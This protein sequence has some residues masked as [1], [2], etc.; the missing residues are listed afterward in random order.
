MPGYKSKTIKAI[1]TKK[2]T[3]WIE[4]VK[5]ENLRTLLKRDVI[6]TGGS[7]ASMLQGE[8]VNDFDIYFRT[9]ETTAKVAQYYTEE[10]VTR[11]GSGNHELFVDPDFIWSKRYTSSNVFDYSTD[12]STSDGISKKRV[13]LVAKS[14][15]VLEEEKPEDEENKLGEY[16]SQVLDNPGDVEDTLDDVTIDLTQSKEKDDKFRP[17]FLSSNAITL[18]DKIQLVLR[19]YGEPDEIHANYDFVHCTSY[20]TSRDDKLVLRQAAL[21]SIMSKELRYVGSKYPVCSLIRLRKFIAR[22]WRVNA[23]QILKMC[24]Q[25]NQFD[26]TDPEVLEDQLTGVDT[27]YFNM[28]ISALKESDSDVIDAAYICTIV[29][30]MF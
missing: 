20:W 28:L 14:I 13:K 22:D 21:E 11:N 27:A 16:I 10:F 25:V 1:L 7:I 9:Y 3:K 30:K 5:D 24:L 29:D 2:I 26:L 12:I 23:G 6:V 8:E 19:F 18:S 15:G 17:V 4:S